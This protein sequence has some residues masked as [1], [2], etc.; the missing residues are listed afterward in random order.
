[1]RRG[2]MNDEAPLGILGETHSVKRECLS[3]CPGIQP[4]SIIH[5][6][7]PL[8][9]SVHP[10]PFLYS[11]FRARTRIRLRL[12]VRGSQISITLPDPALSPLPPTHTFV[13]P[14]SCVQF[15]QFSS[16]PRTAAYPCTAELTRTPLV[17]VPVP[18]LIPF[19]SHP[20]S[21]TARVAHRRAPGAPR[22]EPVPARLP[23]AP[24]TAILRPRP[25]SQPGSVDAAASA[26]IVQGS[27]CLRVRALIVLASPTLL[28]E[29]PYAHGDLPCIYLLRPALVGCVTEQRHAEARRVMLGVGKLY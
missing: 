11:C 25:G 29:Y 22:R 3:P 28:L 24:A 4:L 2:H 13:S 14:R 18:N 9:P 7:T 10:S 6:P 1:M 26:A 15:I 8:P 16:L 5:R 23:A 12:R 20:R 21:T 17:L 19:P 27:S